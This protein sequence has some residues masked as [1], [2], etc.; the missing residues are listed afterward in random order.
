MISAVL[1]SVRETPLPLFGVSGTVQISIALF[2]SE[3]SLSFKFSFFSV[4][5]NKK[6]QPL[7]VVLNWHSNP[8]CSL[9]APPDPSSELTESVFCS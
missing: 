7:E 8:G 1:T 5:K 4:L 2:H 9:L 3:S 6:H